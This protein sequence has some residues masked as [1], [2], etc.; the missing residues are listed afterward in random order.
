[1]KIWHLPPLSGDTHAR[2]DKPL[3]SS[4]LIHKARVLSI[5]WSA[6]SRICPVAASIS[7]RPRAR[8]SFDVLLSHSAP[9]LMRREG[10][11]NDFWFEEGTMVIWR[12]LGVDRFFPPGHLIAKVLRGCASVGPYGRTIPVLINLTVF[13]RIIKKAACVFPM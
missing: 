9:A 5:T 1:M 8:L 3:F 12:W 13:S 11:K 4:S 10:A 7:I 6:Y 2:Q